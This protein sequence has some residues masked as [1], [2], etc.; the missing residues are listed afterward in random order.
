[1]RIPHLMLLL[2]SALPLFGTHEMEQKG[3]H[4]RLDR[5]QPNLTGPSATLAV[6]VTFVL[7]EVS[8][9]ISY[10][11]AQCDCCHEELNK[12]TAGNPLFGYTPGFYLGPIST[13]VQLVAVCIYFP[14]TS[15]AF[16]SDRPYIN[17]IEFIHLI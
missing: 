3:T 12:L 7:S 5:T 2:T 14:F 1:M 8:D 17:T 4:L 10:P 11:V 16:P 15:E 6:S 9:T 13:P